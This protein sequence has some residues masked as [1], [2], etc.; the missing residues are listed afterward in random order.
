[1][2]QILFILLIALCSCGSSRHVQEL[3]TTKDASITTEMNQSIVEQ[4]STQSS[5]ELSI[6]T[7]IR[8]EGDSE[9]TIV[10][11]KFD[12]DTGNLT[13]RTT[14]TKKR[15]ATK[16]ASII[17]GT[18]ADLSNTEGSQSQLFTKT[19]EKSKATADLKDEN[20]KDESTQVKQLAWLTWALGFLGIVVI[21]G[22]CLYKYKQKSVSS[23]S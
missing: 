21:I 19:D 2:R 16:D 10:T 15:K 12:P 5:E 18:K 23:Q 6:S 7:N 9:T 22:Y 11:E 8:E 13:E 17:S 3:H 4:K 20:Q 14:A 1:M